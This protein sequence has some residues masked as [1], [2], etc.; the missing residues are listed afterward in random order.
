M[1]KK[2][3][4]QAF[5]L[6]LIAFSSQLGGTELSPSLREAERLY[7]SGRFEEA[8]ARALEIHRFFPEDF[9]T[10]LVL[11]MSDF[12][13]GNYLKSSDWFRAAARKAPKHPIV[14]R[15]TELLREIEY[16][17][18]PFSRNPDRQNMADGKT[19]AEFYKRGYFGPSLPVPS[20]MDNQW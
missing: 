13:A 11:G 15:Y 7:Q 4:K 9:Q 3:L 16:R 2:P 5:F 6:A 19:A 14:L 20:D 12:H 8:S 17:M 18:G 1:K 10:L